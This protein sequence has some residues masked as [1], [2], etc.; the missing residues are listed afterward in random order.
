VDV[1]SWFRLDGQVA[2]VT[3]GASGIGEATAQVLA[4]AGAAVVVGDL[5]GEGAERTAKAIAADGGQAVAMAANTTV[6]AEVDALVERAVSEFGRLDVM[7]N[8]AGIGYAAPFTQ[9][10]EADFDRLMA[11]NVKGVLFGCQAAARAMEPQGSGS[12]VNVASSAADTPTPTM[13]LYGMTKVSVTYL[14]RTIA[15]ELGP[16]GIRVNAI[17]PGPT[18]TNFAAYRHDGG[19]IDPAKEAEVQK[20]MRAAVPLGFLGEAVDQALMILYLVAP[21]SRWASGNVF[22]VNGGQARF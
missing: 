3:G 13:G 12:I 6:Q 7:C 1:A 17:A 19:V 16:K 5:D 8:V 15:A 10:T 11:I 9:I 21:A 20:M 14:T 2:V 4:G 22:R 18:M